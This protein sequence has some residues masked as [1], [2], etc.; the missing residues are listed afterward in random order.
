MEIVILLVIVAVLVLGMIYVAGRKK[1]H[2]ELRDAFGPEYDRTV[3]ELGGHRQAESELEA[4][5]KRVEQLNI[6][7]LSADT[8]TRF[9]EQWRATQARFVDDPTGAIH[10]ADR[11]VNELMQTRGYPMGDFE[12]RAADISVNHPNVV[13][14]YRAAHRIAQS[15]EAGKADTE[16]LRTAM[17]HYRALFE[18][19]LESPV[20]ITDIRE[21]QRHARAS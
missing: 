4:R 10:E 6:R 1:K 17:V 15:S 14:N 13:T 16:N 11:L 7:P 3:H 8:Q 9:A 2:D 21:G 12:Q 19:L 20:N 18:E 5:R